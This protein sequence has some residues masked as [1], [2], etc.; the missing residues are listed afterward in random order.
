MMIHIRGWLS[1]Q[2]QHFQDCPQ[3]N[4]FDASKK[5]S[6]NEVV[7]QKHDYTYSAVAFLGHWQLR[8]KIHMKSNHELMKFRYI[9][10]VLIAQHGFISAANLFHGDLHTGYHPE[11][12]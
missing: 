6:L 12:L 9:A 2:V 8:H 7:S 1:I 3:E 4:C 10:V 5:I 11:G